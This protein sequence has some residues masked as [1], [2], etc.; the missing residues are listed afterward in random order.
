[1]T[2]ARTARA[3]RMGRWMAVREALLLNARHGC[4]P[5]QIVL[6]VLRSLYCPRGYAIVLWAACGI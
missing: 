5:W 6:L 2:E 1:M 4:R 3:L